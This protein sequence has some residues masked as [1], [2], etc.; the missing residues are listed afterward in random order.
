MVK[1]ILTGA[2]ILLA[3]GAMAYLAVSPGR[4]YTS[5]GVAPAQAKGDGGAPGRPGKEGEMEQ[6][7]MSEEQ[8]EAAR[9]SLT[10]EQYN[11]CVMGGTE[12]PFDNKYYDHHE[13]GSY[14]CIVCGVELFSSETKYD[15]GSGWPAFYAAL[16][17]GRIREIEDLSHGMVR[18]E[19][20][21]GNCDAHLGHLF[22][23]GPNPTGMRY[24]INSASLDFSAE[25]EGGSEAGKSE[26]STEE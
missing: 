15:S 18:T 16:D 8:L 12:R 4:T 3:G 1:A 13:D 9:D 21:C 20:R 11:V 19:V 23:D 17:D 22:N 25:G 14:R 26:G 7:S 10:P 24:C 6:G 2:M 5:N